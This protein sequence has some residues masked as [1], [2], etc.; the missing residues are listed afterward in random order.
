MSQNLSSPAVVIC[1]LRVN[2]CK[3]FGP[4]SRQTK[5]NVGHNLDTNSLPLWWYTVPETIDFGEKTKNKQ[6]KNTASTAKKQKTTKNIHISQ[7][8]KISQ[9]Q[10]VKELRLIRRT[11][12]GHGLYLSHFL[13]LF[14]DHGG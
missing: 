9:N 3:H 1:A 13:L 8:A 7:H 12:F 10:M 2:L 11:Q 4:T 5:Q 14:V 6:T